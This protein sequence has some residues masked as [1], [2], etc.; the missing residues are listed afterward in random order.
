MHAFEPGAADA[1]TSI[2]AR[3]L[4]VIETIAG[5]GLLDEAPTGVT[6]AAHD[7]Q[8]TP[9]ARARRGSRPA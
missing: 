6:V 8:N 7:V 2:P 3:T 5:I 1:A 4:P 9:G